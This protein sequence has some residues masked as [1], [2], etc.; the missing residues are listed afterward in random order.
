VLSPRENANVAD[1][2]RAGAA[3]SPLASVFEERREAG[4]DADTAG[5]G[6]SGGRLR[7]VRNRRGMAAAVQYTLSPS[8]SRRVGNG[9]RGRL[10]TRDHGCKHTSP[11]LWTRDASTVLAAFILWHLIW[12]DALLAR[13]PGRQALVQ[14]VPLV[15][16]LVLAKDRQHLAASPPSPR[17]QT[18]TFRTDRALRPGLPRPWN[19]SAAPLVKVISR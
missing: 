8:Q 5:R 11:R 12:D 17:W 19:I 15:V 6:G 3:I 2:V 18:I 14:L 7:S 16:R 1:I 13:I 4:I 10:L 9:R